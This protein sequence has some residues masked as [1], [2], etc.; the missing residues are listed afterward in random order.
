MLQSLRDHQARYVE[1][2]TTMKEDY[3]EAATECDLAA[4]KQVLRREAQK[5]SLLESRLEIYATVLQQVPQVAFNENRLANDHTS[6]NDSKVMRAI[7]TFRQARILV[8]Q[9]SLT[10]IAQK[11]KSLS[12]TS[13]KSATGT[14]WA[15]AT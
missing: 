15:N 9:V 1:L 10:Q 3:M 5:L 11:K 4:T 12:S 7:V 14:S 8:D 2:L 6:G 13:H